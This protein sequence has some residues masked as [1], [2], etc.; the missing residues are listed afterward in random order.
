MD[1]GGTHSVV[2]RRESAAQISTRCCESAAEIS[3]QD[4]VGVERAA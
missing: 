2:Q 4:V 1:V 3:P